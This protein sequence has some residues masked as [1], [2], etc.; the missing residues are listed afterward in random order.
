MS[1]EILTGTAGIPSPEKATAPVI[2]IRTMAPGPDARYQS[3][4]REVRRSIDL[5]SFDLTRTSGYPEE[6]L[7]AL[8]RRVAV[9][10][11]VLM[12]LL[13]EELEAA[14]DGVRALGREIGAQVFALELRRDPGAVLWASPIPRFYDADGERV[15][16]GTAMY[17]DARFDALVKADLTRP[18]LERLAER[19]DWDLDADDHVI[20]AVVAAAERARS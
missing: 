17:R 18:V 13:V 12:G 6:G 8:Q 10:R 4:L 9:A 3:T 19:E 1:T 11:E 20:V 16:P 2:P 5:A 15:D 14:L 7:T